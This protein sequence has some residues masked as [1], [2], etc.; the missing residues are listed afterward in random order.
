MG[1]VWLGQEA[2]VGELRVR[3]TYS[4]GTSRNA[5]T[6]EAHECRAPRAQTAGRAGSRLRR[7][8]SWGH[9]SGFQSQTVWRGPGPPTAQTCDLR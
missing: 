6:P 3:E 7:N 1:L 5:A 4:T 9:K 8:R 2:S